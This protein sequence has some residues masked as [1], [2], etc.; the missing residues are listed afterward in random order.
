MPR[1]AELTRKRILEAAYRLF[2]RQGYSRVSMDEIAAAAGAGAGAI[3]AEAARGDRASTKLS[4]IG[5][6][7]GLQTIDMAPTA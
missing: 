7:G 3:C 4:R 2:R 6:I 1:S 5:F